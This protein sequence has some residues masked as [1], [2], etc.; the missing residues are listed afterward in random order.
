[1]FRPK[2]YQ[3]ARIVQD[4]PCEEIPL[5]AIA[6]ARIGLFKSPDPD[7][8]ISGGAVSYVLILDGAS[9]SLQ[10]V[11]IHVVTAAI[12]DKVNIV[13]YCRRDLWIW[14]AFFGVARSNN[15]INVLYQSPLFNRFKSRTEHLRFFCGYTEVN[16]NLE[17][18]LVDGIYPELAP[19]V[20]TIPEPADVLMTTSDCCI[21]AKKQ[22]SGKGKMWNRRRLVFL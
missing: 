19:L 18:I 2:S 15:D 4:R 16:Y 9:P 8:H 11:P 22:D 14:H 3:S 7:D 10:P 13:R 5:E 20:K 21:E 12:K 1:M 6:L 17:T